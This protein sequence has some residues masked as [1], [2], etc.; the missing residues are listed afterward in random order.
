M[1]AVEEFAPIIDAVRG[2]QG[3][4][5]REVD[6]HVAIGAT[7]ELRVARKDTGLIEAVW[8]GALTGTVGFS[9]VSTLTTW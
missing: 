5:V 6:D 9:S 4:S 1:L 2:A 3:A 7:D 8:F